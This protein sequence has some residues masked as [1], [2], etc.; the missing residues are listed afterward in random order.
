MCPKCKI[1]L[2]EANSNSFVDLGIAVNRAASLGAVAISNSYGGGEFS[3]ESSFGS[4]Y[5]NHPGVA[6][7]ASSGDSG[8]GVEYPAASPNVIAVGGTTLQKSGGDVHGDGRGTAPAAVAAPTSRSRR[9]NTTRDA[10]AARWPTSPPSPIRPPASWST[11]ATASRA[12]WYIFGGTSVASPIIASIAALAGGPWANPAASYLYAQPGAL[13]DVV[14]GNNGTCGT[15]LCNA[16][17]GFDGPTGLGTPNTTAAFVAGAPATPDF[18]VNATPS[19]V[20]LTTGGSGS[21]TIALTGL[22]G[23]TGSRR[24]PGR[25]APRRA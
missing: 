5:F 6:I 2:V 1:L 18:S 11:T 21:S 19:S 23:F 14:S 22:N 4:T 20:S 15:Y 8:Y 17:A 24:S 16:V 10:R 9:G 12:G 7:T 3:G 13:H 25:S